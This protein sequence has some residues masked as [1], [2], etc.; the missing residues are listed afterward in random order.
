MGG[1]WQGLTGTAAAERF[2]LAALTAIT[3]SGM[4]FV[5]AGDGIDILVGSKFA[6][7][8]RG[9]AGNDSVTGGAGNDTLAGGSGADAFVFD[10]GFGKDTITDFTAGA[11]S[12]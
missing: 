9:G 12:A 11:G 7:D 4:G 5:D 3:G 2:D 1:Q 8:L 6:D 10:A